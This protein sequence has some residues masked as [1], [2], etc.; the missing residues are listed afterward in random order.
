MSNIK[1]QF[2]IKPTV[3][4]HTTRTTNNSTT[5]KR[6]SKLVEGVVFVDDNSNYKI[7]CEYDGNTDLIL[8]FTKDS[9]NLKNRLDIWKRVKTNNEKRTRIIRSKEHAM[10]FPGNPEIYVPFA[11][12]W[13]VNGYITQIDDKMQFDFS[14]IIKPFGY[15]SNIKFYE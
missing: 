2:L 14:D 1:L 4:K 8:D 9:Y 10:I 13:I 11:P 15:T 7:K 6:L 3:V 12:N 5:H